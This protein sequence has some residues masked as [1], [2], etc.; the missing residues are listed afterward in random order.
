M[1]LSPQGPLRMQEKS[2]R[3]LYNTQPGY[4][5]IPGWVEG[6]S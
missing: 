4:E 2:R 5:K 3:D 1:V 6:K